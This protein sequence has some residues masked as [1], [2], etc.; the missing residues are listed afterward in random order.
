MN[1][2]FVII[3]NDFSKYKL[4]LYKTSNNLYYL[5]T[6]VYDG[7]VSQLQITHYYYKHKL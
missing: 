5:V 6:I 4:I 1:L 2:Q 3:E 7:L